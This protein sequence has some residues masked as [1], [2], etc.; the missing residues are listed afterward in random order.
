ESSIGVF[1]AQRAAKHA[2]RHFIQASR[3]RRLINNFALAEQ[4]CEIMDKRLLDKERRSATRFDVKWNAAIKAKE[5]SGNDIYE[6][7]TLENL[8]SF[9]AFV[10]LQNPHAPGEKIRLEI[11]IPF[12]RDNWMS[13]NGE[14]VRL[15][16]NQ[17]NTGIAVRFDTARPQFFER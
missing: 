11:R 13:Y 8:S 1:F 10:F 12:R 16:Q 15:E 7:A 2:D 17:N 3:N 5:E 14:V 6:D 4:N 9:G